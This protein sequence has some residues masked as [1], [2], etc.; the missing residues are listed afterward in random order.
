[1]PV[2]FSPDVSNFGV[3]MAGHRGSKRCRA[4][5]GRTAYGAVHIVQWQLAGD[6]STKSLPETIGMLLYLGE[7]CARSTFTD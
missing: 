4:A 5:T 7:L 6:Y 1:M 3:E 2:A